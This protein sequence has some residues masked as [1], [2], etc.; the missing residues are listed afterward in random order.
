[1]NNLADSFNESLLKPTTQSKKNQ[2]NSDDEDDDND[3]DE[4][5]TISV[6][7]RDPSYYL[8]NQWQS[9]IDRELNSFSVLQPSINH[10]SQSANQPS[11]NTPNQP[12]AF[13][14]KIAKMSIGKSL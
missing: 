11:T 10:T 13:N 5:D 8:S 4:E 14:I 12:V 7:H 6:N 9:H 1:M 2:D 3:D